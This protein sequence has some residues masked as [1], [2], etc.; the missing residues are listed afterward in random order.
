MQSTM[1]LGKGLVSSGLS[2]VPS[3][4]WMTG[5]PGLTIKQNS[6][7]RLQGGATISGPLNLTQSSNGFFNKS[8]G[9]TNTVTGG[10]LCPFNTVPAAYVGGSTAVSPTPSLAS[11]LQSAAKNQCLPF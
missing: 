8:S 1:D 2:T 5:T 6:S 3:L 4:S 7:F 10:I 11:S 9:G